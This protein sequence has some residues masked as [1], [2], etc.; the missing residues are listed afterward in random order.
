MAERKIETTSTM[1]LYEWASLAEDVQELVRRA[2]AAAENAYAPYSGFLVGA[3]VMLQDGQFYSANNQENVCFPVGVCAE[4]ILLGY[5]HANFPNV[6][7]VKMAIVAR[8][9]AGENDYAT[10]TPC[11]LCRQSISEYEL[12]FRLPIDIYMY[13]PSGD[14]LHAHGI[15]QLL[16]LKFEDLNQ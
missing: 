12:K 1:T 11:G 9:A 4:R 7:P 5:T 16:P 10:V 14:V 2:K 15:E 13:M 6:P 3:A 8:R